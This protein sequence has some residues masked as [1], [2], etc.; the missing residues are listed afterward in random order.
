M[1]SKSDT[2]I[3]Q[4]LLHGFYSYEAF[5]LREGLVLFQAP[6]YAFPL[7][8]QLLVKNSLNIFGS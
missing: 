7:V 5:A 6:V 8:S 1:S 2:V 4:D 3:V